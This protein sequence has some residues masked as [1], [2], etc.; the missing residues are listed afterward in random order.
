[1]EEKQEDNIK[2]NIYAEKPGDGVKPGIVTV[3]TQ[4]HDEE[5]LE[6][7]AEEETEKERKQDAINEATQNDKSG[8]G[9]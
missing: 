5:E 8:E 7:K 4:A 6:E 3:S 9:G 1:M 2:V